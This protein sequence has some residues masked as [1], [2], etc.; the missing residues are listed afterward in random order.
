MCSIFRIG[1]KKDEA[2]D[3]CMHQRASAS[4]HHT[5]PSC[6]VDPTM[7]TTIQV[8]CRFNHP[9]TVSSFRH[10]PSQSFDRM[11]LA[12]CW[13]RSRCTSRKVGM[14]VWSIKLLRRPCARVHPSGGGVV[15]RAA[16]AQPPCGFRTVP[17]H[18]ECILRFDNRG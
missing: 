5:A 14:P 9:T 16:G 6:V 4:G 8:L 13:P 11:Q 18:K 2:D 17:Q 12:I 3:A 7:F 10:R 15:C 1:W